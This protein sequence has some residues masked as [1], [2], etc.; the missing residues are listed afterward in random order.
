MSLQQY[1]LNFNENIDQLLSELSEIGKQLFKDKLITQQPI[2]HLIY[3]KN[4]CKTS[5]T[6]NKE[7][8][9]QSLSAYI[10]KNEE[11]VIK[12]NNKD[13]DFFNN[14]DFSSKTNNDN[15]LKLITCI[16]EVFNILN[17]DNQD[18]I[19]EYLQLLC[20]ISLEYIKLK[21]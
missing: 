14:Y 18:I 1:V 20:K 7:I 3:Y 13:K 8:T 19:F 2:D 9:I 12:I 21:Y 16:K 17:K 5:R 15:W 6:L 11:F 4:L 10:L